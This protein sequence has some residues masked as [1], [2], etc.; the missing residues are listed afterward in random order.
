MSDRTADHTFVI[1]AFGDSPYLAECLASIRQQT[2]PSRIIM[3][4][5]T[6]SPP[7]ARIAEQQGVPLFVNAERGGIAADWNYAYAAAGTKYVTIAHQDDLYAAT[8][9]QECL[10]AADRNDDV[11]MVFTD[12]AERRS[13]GDR[14]S[15]LNLNVK[16]AILRMCYLG[17]DEVRTLRRKKYLLSLGNPIPC[18][19]VLFNKARIGQFSFERGLRY[20]L[21]WDAWYR[22]AHREG[23]FVYVRKRLMTHRIHAD[24]ELVKGTAGT[25]RRQEDELLFARFWPR[26]VA[27][28]LSCLYRTSYLT[29]LKGGAS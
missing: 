1:P 10:A 11:L 25:G 24:S 23:A 8:Y 6:P 21:D 29:S 28:V 2:V 15:S 27:A 26:P 4:T 3:T 12:Y 14:S 22:L 20:N 18:P 9:T 16:L 17:S 13:S 5:S 19:S 7:V